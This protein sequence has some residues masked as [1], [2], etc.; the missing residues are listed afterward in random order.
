MIE[1]VRSWGFGDPIAELSACLAGGGAIVF[2]TESSYGLG[3]D[4]RDPRGVEAIYR[5]KRRER[6]KPLPVVIGSPR[7]LPLLGIDPGDDLIVEA[8]RHWPAPL[9]VVA[10]TQVD[11]PAGAGTRTLA[12]RV[13]AHA[14]LRA[15]LDELGHPLTA[16]S[17]NV[18]GAEPW[19]DT[20]SVRRGLADAWAADG[21]E[22]TEE[23]SGG[24]AR[25]VVIEGGRLPGGAPSTVVSRDATGAVRV[26][27]AGAFR[28]RGAGSLGAASRGA[29]H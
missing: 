5:A 15:L 18:A 7:Q 13:P 22:T 10:E 9:T 12:I 11:W 24:R 2:P 19:L 27:R 4:P 6:G 8:S 23:R 29:T 28:W 20:A 25:W 16:T 17:A 1:R 14:A 21:D 26:V 3:V